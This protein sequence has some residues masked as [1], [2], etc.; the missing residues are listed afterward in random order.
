M[1]I[2]EAIIQSLEDIKSLTNYTD[3]CKHII[4]KSY[5][6]FKDAKTPPATISALLGDFIRKG[7]T[8]VKRIKNSDGSFSYYLSKYEHEIDIDLLTVRTETPQSNIHERFKSY[9]E[10]DLHKLLSTYL[11]SHNIFSKTI[12]HERSSN[13]RD[14]HQKWIHPD[15][16]GVSHIKL[17]TTA[18]QT[19][20]KVLDRESTLRFNSYELKREINNDYELKEAFFQAVSNSSWSN[21]GYLVAFEINDSLN[22]EIKR[23]NQSFGIGVIELNSNPY[24]SKLLFP[25]K[26]KEL[27][28]RTIDKLCKINSD[29]EKFII[30]IEKL[31]TADEKYLTAI[32][33]ELEEY[34]DRYFINETEIEKY[35]KEKLIPWD[36]TISE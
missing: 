4:L 25:A 14:K 21:H 18:S 12:F 27:D 29:F 5:Y 22:D 8:R 24:E 1:T 19:L 34:C 20:Q 35:C 11:K 32:E 7:D 13:S 3:V 15:M 26:Y 33:K 9:E 23:L 28:Y 2:K 6:D 36:S 16:V 10:R 31:I 30:Q 17:Q